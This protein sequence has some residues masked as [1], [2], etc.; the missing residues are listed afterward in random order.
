MGEAREDAV[1]V[2]AFFLGK[3]WVPLAF[4][5]CGVQGKLK[6]FYHIDFK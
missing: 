6:F 4:I 2:V 3:R 1:K 5:R